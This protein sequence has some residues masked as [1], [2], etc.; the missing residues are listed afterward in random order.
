VKKKPLTGKRVFLY[1]AIFFAIIFTVDYIILKLAIRSN[2]GVEVEHTY[3]KEMKL[4]KNQ[5][6][7]KE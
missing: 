1:F 4:Q 2:P 7:R 3:E 6:D 5:N